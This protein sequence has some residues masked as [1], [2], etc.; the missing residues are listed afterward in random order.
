MFSL[1]ISNLLDRPVLPRATV[2]PMRSRLAAAESPV[3]TVVEPT[4][5]ERERRMLASRRVNER[6]ESE[7]APF[8]DTRIAHGR[9]R[10]AGRRAEDQQERIAISIKA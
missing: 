2:G 1:K 8:L 6:R 9:R 5:P 4:R 3:V 7:Q 10:S